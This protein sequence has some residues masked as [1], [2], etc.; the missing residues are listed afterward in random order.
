MNRL[1]YKK[2]LRTAVSSKPQQPNFNL[3]HYAEIEDLTL[4]KIKILLKTKYYKND[5]ITVICDLLKQKKYKDD[6]WST[7]VLRI[8]HV[9]TPY[10]RLNPTKSLY[11]RS[12][13]FSFEKLHKAK[14]FL[15]RLTGSS[16]VKVCP[17]SFV[18][19]IR[20]LYKYHVEG[21]ESK[22]QALNIQDSRIGTWFVTRSVDVPEYLF[23]F[24]FILMVHLRLLF[25]VYCFIFSVILSNILS[26]L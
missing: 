9:F 16:W 24:C 12:I 22:K 6:L 13:T 8:L 10:F 21:P 23:P 20:D 2:S 7:S 26:V 18:L 19:R 4:T 11:V 17:F 3:L 1:H 5:Y 15:F 14:M 25:W